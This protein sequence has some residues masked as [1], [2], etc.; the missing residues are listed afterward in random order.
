LEYSTGSVRC[1]VARE[2]CKGEVKV[3]ISRLGVG[4]DTSVQPG[5]EA[6]L[7]SRKLS[8]EKSV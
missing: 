8:A 7:H 1:Q 4:I 2:K 5:R 6:L 3:E